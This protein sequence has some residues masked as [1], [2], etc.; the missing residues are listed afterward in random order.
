MKNTFT[1]SLFMF[2]FCVANSFAVDKLHIVGD[3]LFC[4]WNGGEAPLMYVKGNDVFTFT[5]YF[6]ADKEFKFMQDKDWNGQYYNGSG[7]T[8]YLDL[9]EGGKLTTDG[10]VDA[11]FMM[12]TSG[13]YKI[14]CDLQK[15]TI[16]A[17]TKNSND[18]QPIRYQ[19]LFMVGSATLTGWD[20][21][22][23][24]RLEN[25][26]ERLYSGDFYLYADE[27]FKLSFAP[28]QGFIKDYFFF[29]DEQDAAKVSRDGT[30]DRQWSVSETG[31][32]AVTVNLEDNSISYAKKDFDK[33]YVVGD[34][35]YSGW[36]TNHS[37]MM[38]MDSANVFSYTGWFEQDK[39]FK[40]ILER[41]LTNYGIQIQNGTDTTAYIE[42]SSA[43]LKAVVERM[44][45]GTDHKFK[46][47][48]SGNYKIIC[49]LN[50]MAITAEKIAYQETE[51]HY[52]ALYL[53]GTATPDNE[54][55]EDF[56]T[57][58]VKL[59]SNGDNTYSAA[60]IDL[61][62]GVFKILT[63]NDRGWWTTHYFRDADDA[64]KISEDGT[65]DRKWEITEAGK[66]NITVNMSDKTISIVKLFATNK[67]SDIFINT[68]VYTS[69]ADI[70]VNNAV[71]SVLRL[72][73]TQGQLLNEVKIAENSQSFTLNLNQGIYIAILS[74]GNNTKSYK[75][76]IR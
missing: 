8:A 7:A 11:K 31:L 12:Q 20:L 27:T 71:G 76:H 25:Q 21:D 15:M 33:L 13:Y 26:G 2:M 38:N 64:T 35:V 22:K 6:E 66:Y 19:A 4:G 18:E 51:I 70:Y 52:S 74:I 56:P 10:D 36:S 28:K 30:N 47:A 29:R 69:N 54:V 17:E 68:E 45:N 24:L 46:L 42:N 49:N 23:S 61:N 39:E 58:A 57:K 41:A 34:A 53:V 73:S 1:L 48:E 50:T 44:G 40:F 37:P 75:L 63:A 43:P 55:A 62:A 32:Y 60:N 14:T 67:P 9:D 3:A 16:K 5:G 65:E 72:Y 59:D